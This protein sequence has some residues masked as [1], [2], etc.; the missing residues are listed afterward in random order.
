MSFIVPI[1]ARVSKATWHR[2]LVALQCPCR[3]AL[4]LHARARFILESRTTSHSRA[5][6][7]APS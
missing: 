2:G 1:L 7:F 3:R 4:S 6:A 5:N